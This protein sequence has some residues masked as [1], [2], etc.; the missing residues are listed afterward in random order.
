MSCCGEQSLICQVTADDGTVTKYHV[1][2]FNG[3]V[4]RA[5][6]LGDP[7]ETPVPNFDITLCDD[8]TPT[9][10]IEVDAQGLEWD[11]DNP[12][13]IDPADVPKWCIL[14]MINAHNVGCQTWTRLEDMLGNPDWKANN[15]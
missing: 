13:W 15:G 1:Y 5:F 11:P 9:K 7:T 14:R 2:L 8:E 4:T 12:N 10:V 3:R 6:V